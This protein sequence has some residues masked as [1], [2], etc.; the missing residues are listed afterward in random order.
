MQ[1]TLVGDASVLAI[2]RAATTAEL[3]RYAPNVPDPDAVLSAIDGKRV[4]IAWVG[5][6]CDTSGT[7]H[8]GPSDLVL[9][10][11][12]RPACDAQGITKGIVLTYDTPV[13]PATITFEYHAFVVGQD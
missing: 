12:P 13:D 5:G 7:L 11:D 9:V 3:E 2:W 1:I 6:W 4:L 8:V 10:E